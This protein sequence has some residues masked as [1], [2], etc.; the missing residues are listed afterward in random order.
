MRTS[1]LLIQFLKM[2]LMLK[3][4]LQD[5]LILPQQTSPTLKPGVTVGIICN[6]FYTPYVSRGAEPEEH[7]AHPRLIQSLSRTTPEGGGKTVGSWKEKFPSRP[8]PDGKS[9]S[10][11]TPR[12]SDREG[13]GLGP[14]WRPTPRG[15]G[16]SLGDKGPIFVPPDPA[17]GSERQV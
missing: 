9:P 12:G 15:E 2:L 7:T 11:P 17:W 6:R 16:A 1:S 5:R 13:S 14:T 4:M 10:R 8:T 3:Q